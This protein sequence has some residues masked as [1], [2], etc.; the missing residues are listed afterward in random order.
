M[1]ALGADSHTDQQA[2]Q[3]I[4]PGARSRHEWLDD[5][6]LRSLCQPS[7]EPGP[8]PRRTVA[9]PEGNGPGTPTGRPPAPP[10]DDGDALGASGQVSGPTGWWMCGRGA[11]L[12]ARRGRV[13]TCP[14]MCDH[15]CRPPRREPTGRGV[16][17]GAVRNPLPHESS[18]A[19]KNS[20]EAPPLIRSA[21]LRP[22][23][24]AP[25]FGRAMEPVPDAAGTDA[26]TWR[27]AG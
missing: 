4:A 16:A 15:R 7:S 10:R 12:I 5:R 11:G 18:T 6:W 3:A 24:G 26:A 19:T 20:A 25:R 17:A 27:E 22:L 13:Q 23:P 14:S 9:T 21:H 2:G 8:E 1:G